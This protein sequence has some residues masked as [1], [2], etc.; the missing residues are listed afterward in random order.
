[1]KK[2]ICMLA[3]LFVC[4]SAVAQSISN[5]SNTITFNVSGTDCSR[6]PAAGTWEMD[7]EYFDM[8]YTFDWIHINNVTVTVTVS[9]STFT[10][11]ASSVSPAINLPPDELINTVG[12]IDLTNST[13]GYTMIFAMGYINCEPLALSSIIRP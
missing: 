5:T 9:G 3:I 11:D 13:T 2:T 12:R 4:Y 8:L 10:I 1:M 7:L 6:T